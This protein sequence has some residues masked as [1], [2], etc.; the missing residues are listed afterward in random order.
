[1]WTSNEMGMDWQ[2]ELF[3]F[4]KTNVTEDKGKKREVLKM[5]RMGSFKLSESPRLLFV[6]GVGRVADWLQAKEEVGVVASLFNFPVTGG[7]TCTLVHAPPPP[8]S[9]ASPNPKTKEV[10]VLPQTSATITHVFKGHDREDQDGGVVKTW[11]LSSREGV[12]VMRTQTGF[13]GEG[14]EVRRSKQ[15]SGSSIRALREQHQGPSSATSHHKLHPE[16]HP[17]LAAL[18]PLDNSNLPPRLASLVS[19]V[20]G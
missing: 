8:A 18:A 9:S 7:C 20:A 13:L 4:V 16:S 12:R 3:G 1:M 15:Y 2:V 5:K 6:G 17:R 14:M 11:V 19:L 10:S